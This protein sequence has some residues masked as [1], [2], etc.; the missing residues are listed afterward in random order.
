MAAAVFHG[1]AGVLQDGEVGRPTGR[2]LTHRRDVS[3]GLDGADRPNRQGSVSLPRSAGH[4]QRP[5]LH[6]TCWSAKPS[7]RW[8][9]STIAF[10]AA[11]VGMRWSPHAHP[12][13]RER[14]PLRDVR[15]P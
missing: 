13:A 14:Q 5:V 10:H 15:V 9:R 11:G 7:G 2:E 12:R 1:G 6:V 8:Y 4:G 3:G